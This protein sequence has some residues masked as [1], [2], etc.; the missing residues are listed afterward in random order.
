MTDYDVFNGDADGICALVQLRNAEFRDAKLITGVKRDIALLDRVNADAGDRIVVLDVSLDKNRAH[1]TRVLDEGA[2]VFYVDH[3]FAGE[4]PAHGNLE[5]KIDTSSDV[6]TSM[7]VNEHLRGAF[8]EWAVVGAFGDNLRNSAQ[9]LAEKAGLSPRQSARLERLGILINYNGYGESTDDLHFAP[10]TLFAIL[11]QYRTPLEFIEA[12]AKTYN[13]LDEGYEQDIARARGAEVMFERDHAAVFLLPDKAWARRV[14]GVYGNYLA[15]RHPD[16]AHAIL[17]KR[18]D[19][20]YLIS[21]RAPLSRKTGA[22]E[23]CRQFPSGGGRRA[24]A[25]VND[26]PVDMLPRFVETFETYY[27]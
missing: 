23:I 12:D 25:G 18:E 1:L 3:H 21:V 4:I 15:N 10:D 20:G 7:L 22:D 16:R 9:E 6:C 19:A 5:A 13:R 11:R 24:A 17:L 8:I 14:S 27:K 2:Q 26:L